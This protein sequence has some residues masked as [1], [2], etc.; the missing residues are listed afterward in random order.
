MA[1]TI[2][3][4]A[5]MLGHNLP[6]WLGPAIITI[7]M[8]VWLGLTLSAAIRKIHPERRHD[9]SPH[10]GPIEGG[11]YQYRPGMYSHSYPP[12]FFDPAN[13]AM[14]E[15]AHAETAV[16]RRT[17]TGKTVAGRLALTKTP[18]TDAPTPKAGVPHPGFPKLGTPNTG[19]PNETSANRDAQDAPPSRAD[20]PDSR[21]RR[22]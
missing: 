4:D 20:A 6:Y 15:R 3:A 14:A 2:L 19:T 13:K 21:R 5:S 11:L 10:R 17:V 1:A 7:S 9:Q 16:L 22:D 18:A 12:H 8:V